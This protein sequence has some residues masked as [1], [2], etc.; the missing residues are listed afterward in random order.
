MRRDEDLFFSSGGGYYSAP[1]RDMNC[2]G[3][4]YR[5]LENL[6]TGKELGDII[7]AIDLSVVFIAETWIDKARLNSVLCK[8]DFDHKWVVPRKG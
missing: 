3:W 2:L 8:I 7:C 5:G 4:N 1:P 6:F